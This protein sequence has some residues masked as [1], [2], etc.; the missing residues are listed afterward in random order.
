MRAAPELLG[1]PTIGRGSARPGGGGGE[2]IYTFTA[3]RNSQKRR[4]KG[5]FAH[6]LVYN[7]LKTLFFTLKYLTRYTHKTLFEEYILHFD[8]SQKAEEYI[9]FKNFRNLSHCG[10]I[11]V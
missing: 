4:K 10:V 7:S 8:L 6:V 11:P 3:L 9:N 1:A 5:G 2:V